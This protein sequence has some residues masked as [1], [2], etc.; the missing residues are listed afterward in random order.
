VETAIKAALRRT[1]VLHCDETGVRRGERLAWAHVASTGRLTQYAIHAKRGSEATDAVDILP[2]FTGVSLHDGWAG[3][4]ASSTCRHALCN[5]HHLRELTFLE[6]E[7]HQAW[8]KDL[9]EPLQQMRTAADQ[10][11]AQGAQQLPAAQRDTLL[12][13]YRDLLAA[14]LAAN[15][16]PTLRRRPGQRGRLA[17]SPATCSNGWRS[18]RTRCSPSSTT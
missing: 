8:A 18:G 10:A 11:R 12:T 1:P 13:R 2:G 3:Y 15:P 9:K 6:E 7:Y 16:P 5:V 17:Q 14:G 4:R